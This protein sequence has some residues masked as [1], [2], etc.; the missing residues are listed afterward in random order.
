MA[1][2]L[3]IGTIAIFVKAGL[4]AIVGGETGFIVLTGAVAISA[5]VGGLTGG[6]T[7]T[8][9]AGIVEFG[10]SSSGWTGRRSS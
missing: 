1:I 8:I 7:A 4:N 10:R 2:G 9:L 3:V 6:L 5:W